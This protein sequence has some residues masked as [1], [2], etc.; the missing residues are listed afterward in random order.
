MWNLLSRI[1]PEGGDDK[2]AGGCSGIGPGLGLDF[3][4]FEAEVSL[5]LQR[6]KSHSEFRLV[7]IVK[8]FCPKK[9][10]ESVNSKIKSKK[11]VK[12]FL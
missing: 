5:S 7:S 2:V 11:K 6:P 1:E 10:G 8:G 3:G 12:M 9:Y 4:P